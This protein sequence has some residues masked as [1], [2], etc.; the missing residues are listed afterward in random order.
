[1]PGMTGIEILQ[2]VASIDD[3]I[4]KIVMTGYA[5]VDTAVDCLREGA[6]D[7]IQK[8]V[9]LGE[10][11][12]LIKR[13]LEY[14]RLKLENAHYQSNLENMVRERSEKLAATLEEVRRSYQFTLEAMV[15]MLDAREKQTGRHSVRT[16]DL[17][18]E[19][20]KCMGIAGD[21]L[22]V[23]SYGAFLHDI[24]KIAVPDSILLKAGPLDE[25]EWVIMRAHC[26]TGYDILSSSPYLQ[27]AAD[28][29]YAHHEK[30]DGSG[31]PRGLSG[32]AICIGARIFTVIDAYDAMRSDR[33]YRASMTIPNALA[34][35]RS[36]AGAHFDPKVVE[37]FL[38]NHAKLEEMLAERLG[39][40]ESF[41][42]SDG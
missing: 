3:T 2:G 26:Q 38:A 37:T 12:A 19:L 34:E 15:A 20:A 23:I 21:D 30:F 4:V 5:T 18:V 41:A 28:I 7:F 9:R 11:S 6:Y 10:L 14:R 35:I 36:G 22:E 42:D 17:A 39:L 27:K 13:A 25:A 40:V 33:V 1:M 31:Y 16:R 32:E 8:P 24:G 29:V